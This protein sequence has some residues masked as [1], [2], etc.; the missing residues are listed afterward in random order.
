M[1]IPEKKKCWL[2]IG[3]VLL[4]G[5]LAG[6]Q[7]FIGDYASRKILSKHLLPISQQGSMHIRWEAKHLT[8]EFKG[9]VNQSRMKIA[10]DMVV[11]GGGIQHFSGLDRLLVDIYFAN[12]EG[13]VLTR[14][15]FYT[16]SRAT[17]DDKIPLKFDR[18]YKLPKGT[19]HIAFGY[20]GQARE[21][22]SKPFEKKGEAITHGFLHSPFR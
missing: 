18:D 9:K 16:T 1:F 13:N 6:C 7:A 10:G 8:I 11:S 2:I 15:K 14:K 19:T 3:L 17:I 5:S 20:E 22:G 21:G 4:V 12:P